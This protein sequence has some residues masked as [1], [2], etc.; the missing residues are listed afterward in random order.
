[1]DA[2][3][4]SGGAHHAGRCGPAIVGSGAVSPLGAGSSRANF[5]PVVLWGEGGLFFCPPQSLIFHGGAWVSHRS[6]ES[7][8]AEYTI[9]DRATVAAMT[10]MLEAVAARTVNVYDY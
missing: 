5:E 3:S 6:V 9:Q 2:D 1:M 4:R 10:H 8:A 7:L